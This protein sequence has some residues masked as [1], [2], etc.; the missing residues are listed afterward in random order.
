MFKERKQYDLL[1]MC[2][3]RCG[4]STIRFMTAFIIYGV[5]ML[6]GENEPGGH[7]LLPGHRLASLE[8]RDPRVVVPSRRDV[9]REC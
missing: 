5:S 2:V 9:T 8:L 3:F 4:L 7:G 6:D 1:M